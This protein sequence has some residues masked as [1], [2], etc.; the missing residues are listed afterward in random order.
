M[1]DSIFKK[2][3]EALNLR[4]HIVPLNARIFLRSLIQSMHTYYGTLDRGRL[5]MVL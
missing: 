1:T 4:T 2:A 3:A 5:L